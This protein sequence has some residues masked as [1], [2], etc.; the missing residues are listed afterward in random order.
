MFEI[1]RQGDP[2]REPFDRASRSSLGDVFAPRR[3]FVSAPVAEFLTVTDPL[4]PIVLHQNNLDSTGREAVGA[5][6]SERRLDLGASA[7][8]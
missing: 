4:D 2:A 5:Q 1:S 3:I 7:K 8:S 6:Y